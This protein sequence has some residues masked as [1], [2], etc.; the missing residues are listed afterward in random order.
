[1]A[2]MLLYSIVGAIILTLNVWWFSNVASVYSLSKPVRL[3]DVTVI[4]ELSSGLSGGDLPPVI[5]ARINEIN[6]QNSKA[7]DMLQRIRS[8]DDDSVKQI[9]IPTLKLEELPTQFQAVDSNVELNV[10]GVDWGPILGM[11]IRDKEEPKIDVTISKETDTYF[12]YGH[13]P[14]KKSFTF[15]VKSNDGSVSQITDTIAFAI[16]KEIATQSSTDSEAISYLTHEEYRSIMSTLIDFANY[17]Q[18]QILGGEKDK[19]LDS[20]VERI[21][22]LSDKFNKW[23]PL[24]WFAIR[25][26]SEDGKLDIAKRHLGHVVRHTKD[27]KEKEE[28][29]KLIFEIDKNVGESVSSVVSFQTSPTQKNYSAAEQLNFVGDKISKEYKILFVGKSPNP[30]S[31]EIKLKNMELSDL[32]AQEEHGFANFAFRMLEP[33]SM[34]I[35]ESTIKFVEFENFPENEKTIKSIRDLGD[36]SDFDVLLY[37]Y[38]LNHQG[39][40]KQEILSR[41]HSLNE[42][43]A[44]ISEK[45]FVV[46]SAGNHG[47]EPTMHGPVGDK[48]FNISATDKFGKRASYSGFDNYSFWAPGFYDSSENSITGTSSAAANFVLALLEILDE[49]GEIDP[50]V[51]HEAI[52]GSSRSLI[53]SGPKLVDVKGAKN[54]IT[55]GSEP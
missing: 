3:G 37:T 5:L 53:D 34:Y 38:G 13:Y 28:A 52:R 54:L 48:I 9:G 24:Q 18:S 39:L 14:G 45:I 35:P 40:T 20:K 42:F 1:M 44:E 15:K 6:E 16:L 21:F 8:F 27:S 32:L 36:L 23:S 7:I 11:I 30:Q 50:S 47:F 33:L 55:S 31:S 49:V 25:L 29:E 12:A 22:A 43:F 10:A 46:T 26:A 2:Q 41:N 4:G 19:D 17:K 51:V